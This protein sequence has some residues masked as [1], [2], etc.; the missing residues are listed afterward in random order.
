[1]IPRPGCGGNR[2]PS[3]PAAILFRFGLVEPVLNPSG[4][5]APNASRASDS[6]S[7]PAS[8]IGAAAGAATKRTFRCC[9]GRGHALAA[10]FSAGSAITVPRGSRHRPAHGTRRNSIRGVPSR[11]LVSVVAGH[12]PDGGLS[13][14]D[15][16]VFGVR[17][18][19]CVSGSRRPRRTT[20]ASKQRRQRSGGRSCFVTFS[21]G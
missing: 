2:F 16:H 7:A 17:S 11:C 9:P 18:A 19:E 15:A 4:W 14:D 12:R 21:E 6:R 20:F 10:R 13:R 5:R 3:R 1:M 8:H